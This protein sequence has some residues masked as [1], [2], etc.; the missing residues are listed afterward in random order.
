MLL[1]MILLLAF[2]FQLQFGQFFVSVF[3]L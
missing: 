3:Q 2:D 1:A